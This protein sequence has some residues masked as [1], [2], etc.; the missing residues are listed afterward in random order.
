[1]NMENGQHELNLNGRCLQL[2]GEHFGTVSR[3][4]LVG[5]E[6]STQRLGLIV[7]VKV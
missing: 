2:A 7:T 1:M 3:F 5:Y 4:Y 6:S